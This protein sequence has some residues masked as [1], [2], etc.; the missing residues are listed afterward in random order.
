MVLAMVSLVVFAANERRGEIQMRKINGVVIEASINN[1]STNATITLPRNVS[2]FQNEQLKELIRR[3]DE[4]SIQLGYD[5]DFN[6]E[7]EGV[8]T[9]VSADVPV[10]ISCKDKM[11]KLM[12]L[13]VNV[14][15][16][17]VQL[18]QLLEDI[19]PGQKVDALEIQ[20][21][22]IRYAKVTVGE[23]LEKLKSD[24]NLVTYLKGDVLMS[25][26]VFS[27]NKQEVSYTFE[28]NIKTSNL[29]F[30]REEDVFIK[31]EAVSTLSN[32]TKIEATVGDTEGE[33]RK[34]SYFNIKT[35]AELE[36]IAKA[37]IVKFKYTGFTGDFNAFG[38]PYIEIGWIAEV[39][40][41]IYPER[42]GKY[43]VESIT[44]TFD[45]SPQFDRKITLERKAE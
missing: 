37:D 2:A 18:Q 34:L 14:S 45:D 15:Y 38:I 8:V 26:K 25:G 31:I 11:F 42:D 41:L 44:T 13:P 28:R 21:G 23:V 39:K 16:R 27:A 32:G 12:Q 40:S 1:F 35:K 17:N 24:Y 4:V 43:L 6:T 29:A 10:V 30:R 33:L 22:Q 5:G 20:L 19:L 36:D 7:F 9:E 3:G